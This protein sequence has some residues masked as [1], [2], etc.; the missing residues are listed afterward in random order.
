[1]DALSWQQCMQ[2]EEDD[3]DVLFPVLD[4]KGVSVTLRDFAE[5]TR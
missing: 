2:F 4:I 1:M 5:E 3:E